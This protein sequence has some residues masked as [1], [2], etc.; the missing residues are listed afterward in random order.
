LFLTSTAPNSRGT[1]V[2]ADS[3]LILQS[4]VNAA[5]RTIHVF[6]PVPQVAWREGQTASSLVATETPLDMLA[7]R[8]TAASTSA[9]QARAAQADDGL[10]ILNDEGERVP[11]TE[12]GLE[13]TMVIGTGV[14]AASGY[15]LLNSRLGLWLLGLLTSQ[16]LWKQFDPLEVLYAWEE[17]EDRVKDDQEEETLLSLVD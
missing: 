3:S 6:S 8:V 17:E 7:S 4:S 15:V 5:T 14:V 11:W 2:A 10:D 12:P 13:T 1:D 16:P 9:S